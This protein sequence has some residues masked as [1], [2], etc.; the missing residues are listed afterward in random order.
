MLKK[1]RKKNETTNKNLENVLVT[2]DN[3]LRLDLDLTAF[4]LYTFIDE[5]KLSK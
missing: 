3:G 1:I 2:F 5:F 4:D